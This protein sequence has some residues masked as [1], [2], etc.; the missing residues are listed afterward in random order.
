METIND[1]NYELWLLRYVEQEL[2]PAECEAVERWLRSHPVAAEELALY[3]EAPRLQKNDGVKYGAVPLHHTAPLWGVALRWT[4][5]AAAV[6]ALILP[7]ALTVGKQD[8]SP[9]SHVAQVQPLP[10]PESIPIEEITKTAQATR[11]VQRAA[12]PVA[13]NDCKALAIADE[14]APV[15]VD[16]PEGAAQ[17]QEVTQMPD[18]KP[19]MEPAIRYV[20]DLIVVVDDEIEPA[21]ESVA[22]VY[23]EYTNEGIALPRLIGS[24]LKSNIKI[25]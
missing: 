2:T 21:A 16:E 7:L 11:P 4:A 5:A 19:T 20:D 3:C 14:V 12:V 8:S 15:A 13:E 25:Q 24:F 6:A 18:A 9:S 1:N 10:P 17:E 22:A 23:V